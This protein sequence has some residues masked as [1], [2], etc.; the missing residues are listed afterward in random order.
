MSKTIE[1]IA[2]ETKAWREEVHIDDLIG[3]SP[4]PLPIDDTERKRVDL[5]LQWKLFPLAT[6]ALAEHIQ[7]G[8]D[9]WCNGIPEWDR[10][11]S[12]D[13]LQSLLR[14]AFESVVM[15]PTK[16]ILAAI[17]WR[18]L[19]RLEKFLEQQQKED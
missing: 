8:G 4:S 15:K 14:H 1:E 3:E 6:V 12:P 10:S 18:A 13:E 5:S 9:K 16:Y 11:K 7:G 19:A 17:A 2:E